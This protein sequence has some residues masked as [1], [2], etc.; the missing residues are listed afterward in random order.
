[1]QL[2]RVIL[3]CISILLL[4]SSTAH[5]HR[6]VIVK[7]QSS[8]EKP[9]LV[10]E[11]EISYAYYGELVGEPHYYRIVYPKEFVLYANIL[12]PDFSPKAEPIS[13]HDM[14]FQ[15][16]AEGESLFMAEGNK[17]E[18]R[19]FYERYGRDHYYMGPE[20]EQK[21]S[22]GTYHI[23]IFNGKNVG[24]YALAIG[25]KESFT[26]WGLVGAMVKARSLDKWFFKPDA[27]GSVME[28]AKKT[29]IDFS[30]PDEKENWRIV[31]DIVM[32]GV[33]QSEIIVTDDST[34]IFQGMLSLENNG[35]FASVRTNPEDYKM[36]GYTAITARVRGDGRTYQL[37]LRTDDRFDGI[38]Y[39]SEFQTT[40]REWIT[41]RLP[42]SEFVA[43]FHGQRVPDA[44]VLDPGKI[45][46]IGFLISDKKEGSFRL[47]ID[48]IGAYM[49]GEDRVDLGD[50]IWKNRLL[51]IFSPSESHPDYKAQKRELEEQI[52][53]VE[54]RDLIVFTMLEEGESG[55][56]KSSK[57]DTAAESLRNQ[58]GI[59]PGQLTVILVG[60]DGGEKLR[61]TGRVPTEDIFS[62]IDSMPMRQA[63]MKERGVY[64]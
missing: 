35:G 55:I 50:Y 41:L 4:V 47:E 52:A 14:S 32:G 53:E 26:P 45:R 64:K 36:A 22:A 15:I 34:A 3:F 16:L 49:E 31:N 27:G 42:F 60:K 30:K 38:S 21:V 25:K 20:F 61:S 5:A 19:R 57:S 56:G 2:A 12:V 18:W 8:R 10:K 37:R 17:S 7:S 39:R 23:K 63:E 1:M 62:L 44:P 46:Q 13:K 54:D 40:D 59:E 51:L 28:A 29:L 48:W 24:K 9:V 33:S 6:P 11:P 43:T 58:F